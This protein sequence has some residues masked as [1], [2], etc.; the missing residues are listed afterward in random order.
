MGTTQ[1]EISK[2]FSIHIV[3]NNDAKLFLIG[4]K[5]FKMRMKRILN[6]MIH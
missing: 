2:S 3:F 1:S 4:V 5:D 6:F